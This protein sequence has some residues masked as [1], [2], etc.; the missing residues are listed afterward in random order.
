MI[1]EDEKDF[2]NFVRGLIKNI[3]CG[4]EQDLDVFD[5]QTVNDIFVCRNGKNPK[6]FFI[7]IKY[8][9]KKKNR[10]GIGEGNGT[11]LQL[12]ILGKRPQYLEDYLKWIITHED[13]EDCYWFIDNETLLKYVNTES[14]SSQKNISRKLFS[15]EQCYSQ[16]ELIDKLKN[17]LGEK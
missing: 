7:E 2:E 4:E 13:K 9:T 11:G 10:V 14:N 5:H 1:F 17:W 12:E 15:N 16:S 8:F 6:V 3:E